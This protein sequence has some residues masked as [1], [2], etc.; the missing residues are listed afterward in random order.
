MPAKKEIDCIMR[1]YIIEHFS[2]VLTYLYYR[3]N[4]YDSGPIR[5]GI[6]FPFNVLW[7]TWND[8]ITEA[9]NIG[10]VFQDTAKLKELG[11]LYDQCKNGIDSVQFDLKA[12]DN[13]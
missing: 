7:D 1:K 9:N 4:R 6:T 12:L 3:D 5:Y 13:E 11:S 10:F 8:L 2:D